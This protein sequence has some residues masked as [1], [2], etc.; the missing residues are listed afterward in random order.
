MAVRSVSELQRLA[1][2]LHSGDVVVSINGIPTPDGAALAAAA[3]AANRRGMVLEV[4]RDGAHITF[5][6]PGE[7]TAN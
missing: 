3:R 6:V 4:M 7:S 2:A 1:A 5:E